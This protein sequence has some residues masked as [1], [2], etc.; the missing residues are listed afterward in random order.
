MNSTHSTNAQYRAAR[1]SDSRPRRECF[2]Q[3]TRA[4]AKALVVTGEA[5]Q[6]L[7]QVHPTAALGSSDDIGATKSFVRTIRAEVDRYEARHD[8][9]MRVTALATFAGQ[10][11]G[12]QFAPEAMFLHG[13]VDDDVSHVF[14]LDP[15]A[16]TLENRYA[17]EGSGRQ[18]AYG[19]LD[20]E[21]T[22]TPTM[23]ETRR[24]ACRVVGSAAERDGLIGIGVYV[25]ASGPYSPWPTSMV[26]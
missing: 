1:S 15:D 13:G 24:I 16:G 17:A 23:A 25:A 12:A 6:K 2:W 21:A 22:T 8:G 3:P 26:P 4:R 19:V 5:V 10:E 20:A 18:I 14:T 9:V 7:E 11:V